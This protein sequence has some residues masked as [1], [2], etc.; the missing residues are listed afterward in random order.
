MVVSLEQF[1]SMLDIIEALLRSQLERSSVVRLEQPLT[2]RQYWRI[3][4]NGK[5]LATCNR[6]PIRAI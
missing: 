4:G 1:V 2:E 6:T 5:A 3:I